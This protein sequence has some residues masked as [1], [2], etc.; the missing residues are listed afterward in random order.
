MRFERAICV[1]NRHE[2]LEELSLGETV[3]GAVQVC[4]ELGDSLGAVALLEVIEVS[5]HVLGESFTLDFLHHVRV[6]LL[7]CEVVQEFGVLEALFLHGAQLEHV[8]RERRAHQENI[9]RQAD[10]KPRECRND[11]AFEWIDFMQIVDE[12]EENFVVHVLAALDQVLE[13]IV[14]VERIER[15]VFR[16]I[17]FGY[18]ERYRNLLANNP[19][20]LQV[21]CRTWRRLCKSNQPM[22]SHVW[23]RKPI[24][25]LRVDL[26]HQRALAG[27]VIAKDEVRRVS[28]AVAIVQLDMVFHFFRHNR[29]YEALRRQNLVEE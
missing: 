4:R 12:D 25:A 6:V 28:G 27:A 13:P 9:P 14:D 20:E 16:Q 24:D 23:A 5:V 19:K 2:K 18:V 8:N 21:V 17:S 1:L 29:R 3:L 22:D 7:R 10:G 15:G 26:C 11:V